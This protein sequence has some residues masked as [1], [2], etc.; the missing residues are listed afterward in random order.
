MSY[1]ERFKA[2]EAKANSMHVAQKIN[3]ELSDQRATLSAS[4]ANA[5]RWIWELIQN[6]KDVSTENGVLIKIIVDLESEFPHV[7]FKHNGKPFSAE[8]LRYLI[9][10]LSSKDRKK[11]EDGLSKTTGRWGTGFMTTHC[12]SEIVTVNGVLKEDD[13]DFIK[14][15]VKLD[16]SGTDEEEIAK[17]VM[18]AKESLE[19][20]DSK[21]PFKDYNQDKL[22]TEFSYPLIQDVNQQIAKVGIQDIDACLPYS[23]LFVN[24][25]RGVKVNS[26]TYFHDSE[27]DQ[28]LSDNL[29]IKS[30]VVEENKQ[31]EQRTYLVSTYSHTSI[32]L[33]ISVEGDS[34]SILP[35]GDNVPRIYCDFPLV[36]TEKFAFP[37]VI[38][39][40]NFNP[41]EPRDGVFL[42][43][44]PVAQQTI[45]E[46]KAI[47]SEAVNLFYNILDFASKANWFN[48]HLLADI[49]SMG[50]K[51]NWVDESWFKNQVLLPIRSKLAHSKIVMNENGE[52]IS[53][54]QDGKVYA[55]FPVASKKEFRSELHR[56]GTY[57]FPHRLPRENDIE[58]WNKVLWDDCGRVT[59]E[60][61]A[62]W[63]ESQIT[64]EK[65]SEVLKNI[66]TFKWLN[67]FYEMLQLDE[68][69]FHSLVASRKI[70]PNQNG[71]FCLK[72]K[73]FLE[74]GDD[75][76]LFKDV[77]VL[78]GDDVRDDLIDHRIKIDFSTDRLQ[79]S[80]VFVKKINSEVVEKI[81]I[82][83]RKQE[84]SDAFK[85]LLIFFNSFNSQSAELF[86][87]LVENKHWLYDDKE[88]M[89]NITKAEQLGGLLLDFNV[90]T[91]EELRALMERTSKSTT[92]I[93]QVTQ[94]ILTNLG[95]T[96]IDEWHKAL[97]EDKDLESLFSHTSSLD[98]DMFLWAQVY[99]KKTKARVIAH[100]RT[101]PEYNL[102]DID[103]TATTVI[104]GVEKDGRII[105]IVF[106]PAYNGQVII[107]Y[108]SE[109]DSLDFDDSELWVDDG[110]NVRR[111]TF[112]H[113]LKTNNIRKF[114]I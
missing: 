94:E 22:N 21:E 42:T 54:L 46:N 98:P 109:K 74:Q 6:A 16:R 108:K 61:F 58:L 97:E 88:V 75:N 30:I 14:F 55:L 72:S 65:L 28:Y 77:L 100:L 79:G 31:Q 29:T 96:T 1:K 93:L 10:Q 4:N 56:I 41:T 13:H 20:L 103:E 86:P 76:E 27:A 15:E 11:N 12:L 47:I 90:N 23:L 49:T 104:N 92:G 101:L 105:S 71:Q 8:N 24:S 106:R 87:Q 5:R 63:V 80:S 36:G 67:Q 107:Y 3:R 19:N 37:A 78:L 50:G 95:I 34:I 81:T 44:P 53:I 70:F 69:D 66:D 9:D 68:K 45:T 57:W 73:L 39:N 113:I 35:L 38:N 7:K 62:K 82:R 64:V 102:D 32:A 26:F 112:G 83:P 52:L 60:V 40:P 17:A 51:F 91:V 18:R 111:I 2:S 48:L 84:Y 89:E 85:K 43:S 114:P 33:P 25:I 59:F 99:I 110:V